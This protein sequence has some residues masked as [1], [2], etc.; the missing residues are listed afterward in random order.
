MHSLIS[1]S[2]IATSCS[3]RR[4]IRCCSLAG[5]ANNLI[6][7]VFSV[8]A[9]GCFGLVLGYSAFATLPKCNIKSH[10]EVRTHPRP[11]AGEGPIATPTPAAYINPTQSAPVIYNN[12]AIYNY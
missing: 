4:G 8:V 2:T 1:T 7:A 12:F 6:V 3:D 10:R 9:H 5:T 11:G